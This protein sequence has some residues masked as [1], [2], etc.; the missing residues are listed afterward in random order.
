[1]VWDTWRIVP[2]NG[3]LET[4]KPVVP[5]KPKLESHQHDSDREDT[6]SEE[7]FFSSSEDK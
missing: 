3:G 5:T 7:S 4:A 6:L 2:R 1:M